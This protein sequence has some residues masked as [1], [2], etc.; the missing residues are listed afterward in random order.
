[1]RPAT[2][3]GSHVF[4]TRDPCDPATLPNPGYGKGVNGH[5]C[6]QLAMHREQPRRL[7][8]GRE[9]A[10]VCPARY[11]Q[12]APSPATAGA[13][14]GTHVSRSRCAERTPARRARRETRPGRPSESCAPRRRSLQVGCKLVAGSSP[15]H[16]QGIG[17]PGQPGLRLGHGPGA[18][19]CE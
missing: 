8:G 13:R 6:V 1:M 17:Q 16:W 14:A 3:P 7:R 15:R 19:K 18:K 9:R 4:A 11:G 10:R 12:S 2:P 5:A